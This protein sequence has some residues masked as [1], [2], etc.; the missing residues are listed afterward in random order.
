M[1]D[2]VDAAS[3]CRLYVHYEQVGGEC[4]VCGCGWVNVKEALGLERKT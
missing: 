3:Q 1:A 2:V 4:A